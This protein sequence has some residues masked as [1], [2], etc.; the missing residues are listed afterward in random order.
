MASKLG[1][2][3]VPYVLRVLEGSKH[4]RGYEDEV[5]DET[6]QFFHEHLGPDR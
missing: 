3:G 6:V 5:W 4:S 2:K 1:R